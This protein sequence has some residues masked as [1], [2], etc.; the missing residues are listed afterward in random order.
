MMN[1]KRFCWILFCYIP[2]VFSKNALVAEEV[3][4]PAV[5]ILQQHCVR[6]HNTDK[7]RGG[8]DLSNR[9]AALHGGASGEGILPGK[10]LQSSVYKKAHEGTMPPE[11][12]GRPLTASEA[13]ILHD[14]ILQGAEWTHSQAQTHNAIMP[15]I[16]SQPN[17]PSELRYNTHN[18]PTHT[19]RESQQ[20]MSRPRNF[21]RK[22]KRCH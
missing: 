17:L 10:P 4:H 7:E 22:F 2:L 18:I 14:W 8:L 16:I 12:D 11:L 3:F 6:C 21:G 1:S 15:Q 19:F 9:A 5:K 13:Q 20:W